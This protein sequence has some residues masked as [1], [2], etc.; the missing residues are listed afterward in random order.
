MM[1]ESHKPFLDWNHQDEERESGK[2][3][4]TELSEESQFEVFSNHMHLKLRKRDALGRA[5]LLNRWPL[6]WEQS[7]THAIE[8][9]SFFLSRLIIS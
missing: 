6:E 1:L 9:F 2:S 8:K 7:S 4:G 3:R 5:K